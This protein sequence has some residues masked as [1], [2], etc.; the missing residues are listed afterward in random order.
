MIPFADSFPLDADQQTTAVAAAF[1]KAVSIYKGYNNNVEAAKLWKEMAE[2][3]I[4]DLENTFKA[5][6]HPKD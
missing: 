6:T 4:K 1:K 5:T 2:D 3:E